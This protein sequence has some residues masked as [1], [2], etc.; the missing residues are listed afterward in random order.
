MQT[1]NNIQLCLW[2]EF[3]YNQLSDWSSADESDMDNGDDLESKFAS[4]ST[5]TMPEGNDK[6]YENNPTVG[7]TGITHLFFLRM[8]MTHCFCYQPEPTR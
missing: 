3:E 6:K 5:V 2:D 4:T 8:M 7:A 1:K